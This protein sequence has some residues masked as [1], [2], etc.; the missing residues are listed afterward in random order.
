MMYNQAIHTRQTVVEIEHRKPPKW[1]FD[2]SP[3]TKK[4]EVMA[5]T[6]FIWGFPRQKWWRQ[7]C[8]ISLDQFDELTTYP[9]KG[10]GGSGW[11][12][13]ANS[14]VKLASPLLRPG[15]TLDGFRTVS[16]L[17]S[18]GAH[19]IILPIGSIGLVCV[20]TNF[21][22]PYIC[23]FMVWSMQ[24]NITIHLGNNLAKV[25]PKLMV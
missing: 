8:G 13:F 5:I 11:F 19:V 14:L 22:V 17:T 6:W 16:E 9:L 10:V 18:W 21:S 15:N 12:F 20:P 1:V 3:W 4:Q 23:L 7:E 25:T 2:K 24:A